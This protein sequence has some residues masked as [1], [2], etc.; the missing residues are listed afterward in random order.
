MQVKHALYAAA[1]HETGECRLWERSYIM[2]ENLRIGV[3]VIR[4]L[5]CL[6]HNKLL[7]VHYQFCK[8]Y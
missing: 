1:V 5:K 3:V 8:A 4:G 6:I 2:I 7:P